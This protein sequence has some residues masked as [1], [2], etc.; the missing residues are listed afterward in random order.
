LPLI[1]ASK[2][3]PQKKS[4]SA[5]ERDE[6]ARAEF[7]AKQPELAGKKLRVLDESS[8]NLAL[9]THYG[10]APTV[11][12]VYDSV[13]RNYGENI[14]LLA[15]MTEDGMDV[16]STVTSLGGLNKAIFDLYVE[17]TLAPRLCE[18]E[19][20]LMD[21][22]AAHLSEKA[23][24]AIE[25]KGATILFLPAYSPDLSPIELAFSK[26]KEYLRQAKARTKELLSTA[27][28]KALEAITAEEAKAWFRHCGY[29][30]P[31]L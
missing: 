10:Y 23:T 24:K 19:I 13:P 26:L 16:E 8:T 30:I 27:T 5:S 17:K 9:T 12:R 21:N 4:L 28:L 6:E 7:R 25:A 20:V 14:T 15:T 2:N 1:C 3:Y 22:L 18:G 31:A 11:E 29:P